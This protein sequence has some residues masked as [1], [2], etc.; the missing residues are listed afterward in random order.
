MCQ[1]RLWQ[2]NS[3]MCKHGDT[4]QVNRKAG[5]RL[6]ERHKQRGTDGWK[7]HTASLGGGL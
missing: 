2:T 7:M 4:E 5:N 6:I 3:E 1:Q